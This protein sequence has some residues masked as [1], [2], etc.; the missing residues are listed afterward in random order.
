[1]SI[2]SLKYTLAQLNFTVGDIEGNSQLI[3]DSWEAASS[4]L[5]IFPELALCGY[6]PD[7]LILR[8]EFLATIENTI[9]SLCIKSKEFKSAALF[10]A[11]YRDNCCTYNAVYLIDQGQVIA[12]QK[13]QHLPN[14]GV[15]DEKRI[16]TA[17]ETPSPIDFRGAK[18]GIMICEDMWM[19]NSPAKHLA[20]KGAEIFVIVNASPFVE[21]KH[22][23]R[24]SIANKICKEHNL[25]LIYTNL[26][27][28]QDELVFDGASFVMDTYGNIINQLPPF[29][30]AISNI[31]AINEDQTYIPE[32]LIYEAIKVGL[33]DYV[34]KNNFPGV[35]IGLSGGVDS[36]IVAVLAVEALG[37]QN[38][39]CVMMPS[40]F[41]SQNSLDDAAQLAE[42]IGCTYEIISINN[43]VESLESTINLSGLAHENM[44]SRI[45]GLI[46]MSLSNSTG[47]MVVTTGN[48]S[49]M[50]VG[51]ATL[52]GDMCGGFNPLKDIYKTDIYKI[53]AW[54]NRREEKPIIP[55]NILTKAPTAELRDNQTDQDSLPD[56]DVLDSILK[57]VIEDM[58]GIKEICELG[59]DRKIVE[60]V[61]TLLYRSEYKRFQSAPGTVITTCA[62]GR[63]RRYPMTNGYIGNIYKN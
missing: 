42:N 12:I 24:T 37:K 52:Y 45:R 16:F 13:K 51:Y 4:D 56:Y 62:F 47:K 6:P 25:P 32:Q 20:N 39:H 18:L 27:G 48:K 38:V 29:E 31:D 28:G 30:D 1:M 35:L 59:F 41:T 54:L 17:G 5:I 10:G 8:S 50:A 2:F 55:V 60:K 3:L 21:G 19:I 49:E 44:Q 57:M 22:E 33:K 34:K 9:A 63:D 61:I 40:E 26:V 23:T 14:Y 58:L 7:D 46:L 11:P 53:C 43:T 15:F 36:A